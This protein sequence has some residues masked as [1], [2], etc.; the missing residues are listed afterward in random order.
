M[1][2]FHSSHLWLNLTRL[3]VLLL[4]AGL[5]WMTYQSNVLLKRFKPN[6]NLLLSPPE[7]IVRVLLVGICLFLAWLSGLPAAQLGLNSPNLLRSIGFGAAIGL[8]VQIFV[9]VLTRWAIAR[10]GHHLYSPVVVQSILPRR[11]IEWIPVSLALIPAVAME[12]LLFRSLW[13]GVFGLVIPLP[14]LILGTSLIFGF[15][16]QPQ[17]PLGVVLTGSINVLFC[18]LFVWSGELLI[19]L[20][21]HY[22]INLLQLG[23]AYFS[24]DWLESY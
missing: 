10:F 13:L 14:W 5:A 17:G 19:P 11:A 2:I 9:N 18:G 3:A 12:E 23:A 6:F 24:S 15:M 1:A 20:V 8:V 22:T 4:T 21:A 7:L 16:H